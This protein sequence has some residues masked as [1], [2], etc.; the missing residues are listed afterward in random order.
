MKKDQVFG[1]KM[2]HGCFSFHE[3]EVKWESMKKRREKSLKCVY[4][5]RKVLNATFWFTYAGGFR[6]PSL[7]F[8]LPGLAHNNSFQTEFF[9]PL[10]RVTHYK[11]SKSLYFLRVFLDWDGFRFFCPALLVGTSVFFFFTNYRNKCQ[12]P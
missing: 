6:A 12:P 3:F 2:F 8:P 10:T 9:N 4:Y 11:P 1:F 7:Q 5:K